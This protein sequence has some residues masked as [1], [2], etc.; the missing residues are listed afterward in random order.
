V[1]YAGVNRRRVLAPVE[2]EICSVAALAALMKPVQLEWHAKAA[3]RLGATDRQ[4][5]WAAIGQLPHAGFPPIVQALRS[6]DTVL[7][8]WY[9][10]PATDER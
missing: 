10:H 2:R 7:A 3:L 1:I 4:L 6:L 8:D 5:R 9:A